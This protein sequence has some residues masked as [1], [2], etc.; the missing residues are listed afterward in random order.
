MELNN[1]DY[2]CYKSNRFNGQQTQ[3]DIAGCG[4]KVLP[5]MPWQNVIRNIVLPISVRIQFQ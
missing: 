5:S 1:G 2:M 3:N 4:N